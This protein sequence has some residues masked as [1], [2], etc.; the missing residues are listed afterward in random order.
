MSKLCEAIEHWAASR[1]L[2][3]TM[4]LRELRVSTNI[5]YRWKKGGSPQ[6]AT[7][8]RLAARLEV[9]F[10]SLLE[11]RPTPAT[12][13][14]PSAAGLADFILVSLPRSAWAELGPVLQRYG[15]LAFDPLPALVGDS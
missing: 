13:T 11:E 2:S 6:P 15:G 4:A 8:H 1:A 5:F 14:L 7:I 3:V 9:D 12:R 10:A